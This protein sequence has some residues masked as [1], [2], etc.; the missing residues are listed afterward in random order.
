MSTPVEYAEGIRGVVWDTDADTP[1]VGASVRLEA[2]G[3]SLAETRADSDGV[4]AF[5]SGGQLRVAP[6][7]YRLVVDIG[8]RQAVRAVA[9]DASE[10]VTL[11]GRIEV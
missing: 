10:P 5:E 6:G 11:V 1:A 4:F 9:V 3:Q 7:A 2:D 8:D